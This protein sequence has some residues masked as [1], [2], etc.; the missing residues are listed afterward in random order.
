MKVV[1]TSWK[2]GLKK[3]SL[4]GLFVKRLNVSIVL[5]KEYADALISGEVVE[6]EIDSDSGPDFIRELEELG[7][8][9]HTEPQS[10]Q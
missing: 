3:I 5:A 7:V 1:L 9:C 4:Y 2:P 6:L 10:S 8:I